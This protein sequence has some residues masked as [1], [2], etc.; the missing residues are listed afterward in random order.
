MIVNVISESNLFPTIWGG[1]HT[2][3]LNNLQMLRRNKVEFV[4][5]SFGKADITH[6]H[7][8]G[9]FGLYKLL[10]S[11]LIVLT[12]HVTPETHAGTFRTTSLGLIIT[13]WYLKFFY[14]R[15]DLIIAL[16]PKVKNDLKKL[17]VNKK[18]VIISNPINPEVFYKDLNLGIKGRKELGYKENNFI[19]VGAGH[20]VVRK[21][22]DDFIFLAKE[23][24]EYLFIWVG[25]KVA[26]LFAAETQAQKDMITNHPPNFKITG[27][28]PYSKMAMYYNSADALLFPSHG[29]IAS[30]VIIEAA[31]CGLPLIL[32]DLPEYQELYNGSYIPC[33]NNSEFKNALKKLNS[34]K[35]FYKEMVGKSKQLVNNFS[36]EKLGLL[37]FEQYKELYKLSKTNS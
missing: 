34:D 3:F 1:I 25:G 21:G 37:L 8:F 9:P 36:P 30:M 5:N 11:K 26:D 28:V 31:A 33:K 13:R 12:T 17:G 27:Y 6:I 10:T 32:R 35:S 29:E 4:V 7:S 18:M 16:S 20:L 14:N 23:L 22:V 19:V 2:A 15:A 24:P